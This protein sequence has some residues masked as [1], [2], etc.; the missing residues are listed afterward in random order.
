VP[1]RDQCEEE[2]EVEPGVIREDPGED[3]TPRGALA[4]RAVEELEPP[5]QILDPA[6]EVRRRNR[7]VPEAPESPGRLQPDE[8]RLRGGG[9][10]EERRRGVR[11]ADRGECRR[12]RAPFGVWPDRVE[13]PL[14]D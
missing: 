10:A 1:Y 5:G 6:V 3:R 12:K 13:R 4:A 14:G 11:A 9:E 2:R 7:A 8:E